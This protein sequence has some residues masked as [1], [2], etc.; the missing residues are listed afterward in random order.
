MLAQEITHYIKKPQEGDNVVI[1]LDMAKAYDRVSWAFTCIAMR[2]MGF[3]EVFIDLVWRIMSNNW[4]SVIVNGS[5]HGFFHSTRGLKQGDPLSHVLFILGVEV[6]SRML[7]LLHQ[8]QNYKGFHM[9]IGGPQI[10]HL[11][12]AD[13]VIIFTAATRSSLQLIM[14]TLSTY[15][16]VSDQSINKENSHFMVPTNT[17]METIDMVKDIT[18]FYQKASPI[19]YLGCPLYIGGQRIIYYSELVAKVV[20]RISG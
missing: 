17:P 12:F 14:K 7:N 2:T 10:N 19:S 16:A 18:G 6:L 9:Q 1:K 15:E 13:D 8:D 5:R 11:C 3:G 4:Y 20:K